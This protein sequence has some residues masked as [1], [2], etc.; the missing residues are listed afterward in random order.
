MKFRSVRFYIILVFVTT[1]ITLLLQWIFIPK[2]YEATT[3]FF[4]SSTHYAEH[5]LETGLRFGDEKELGEYMELLESND[6]LGR[7][8]RRAGLSQSDDIGGTRFVSLIRG[9]IE[10]SRSPNR[11]LHL[12]V[13]DPDPIRAA[14]LA[15]LLVEEADLHLSEL[16]KSSVERDQKAAY[17]I[18]EI[19]QREVSLLRDSLMVLEQL[20]EG[21]LG[22]EQPETPRFRACQR[23]YEEE[24]ANMVN[25]KRQVERLSNTLRK[26]VPQAYVVSKAMPPSKEVDWKRVSIAL[27]MGFFAALL[28]VAFDNRRRFFA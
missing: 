16:I 27:F 11:S 22:V 28:Q 14:R 7:L 2:L 17:Q 1:F 18:F 15:N 3:I 4:P 26:Q 6:V 12:S 23:L 21:R 9:R 25:L 19:K 13:K 8:S 5:L 20:G 24:I 10:V